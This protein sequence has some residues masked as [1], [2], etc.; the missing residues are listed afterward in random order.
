[1][2]DPDLVV[3]FGGIFLTTVGYQVERVAE[4]QRFSAKLLADRTDRPSGQAW[5]VRLP[6]RSVHHHLVLVALVDL[7]PLD[8]LGQPPAHPRHLQHCHGGKASHVAPP[9]TARPKV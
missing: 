1:M 3:I 7:Q 6:R 9:D 5:P 4:A 2:V 8:V